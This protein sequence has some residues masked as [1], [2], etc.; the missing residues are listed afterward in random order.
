MLFGH[1]GL[2]RFGFVPGLFLGG[3]P[4][5]IWLRFNHSLADYSSMLNINGILCNSGYV[6]TSNDSDCSGR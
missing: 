6:S 5:L 3:I 2:G 1:Y 4:I